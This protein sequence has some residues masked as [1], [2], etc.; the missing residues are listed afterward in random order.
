MNRL[1]TVLLS[2]MVVLIGWSCTDGNAT[3][4]TQSTGTDRG[5]GEEASLPTY[6]TL[7]ISLESK[8]QAVNVTGRTQSLESI[9]LTSEVQG[10]VLSSA[11][12]L[13]EGVSYRKGES[14]LKLDANTFSLNLKSQKSQFLATLVRLMP[15]IKLDYV[16]AHPS[17]DAYVKGFSV[18]GILPDLPEVNN[19]QLRYFLSAN[20]L[21]TSFY[22][23]KSG[24]QTLSKYTIR[25]PFTGVVTS[26]NVSRGAV[27][28]PGVPLAS[29]S[30]TDVF[31]V[32]AAISAADLS[33]IKSG[34]KISLLHTSTGKTYQGTIKRL[35]GSVDPSTQS[36]PVFIQVSGKGLKEGMFLEAS[37]GSG[38]VEQIAEIPLRAMNRTNQVHL[39]QDSIIILK[40]VKPISYTENR[41]WVSGLAE[42]D[43]V[44]IEEIL[45]P[46]VGTKAIP[47]P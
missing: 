1:T 30:R 5:L 14:M 47:Q 24:E 23:L 12:I 25:A 41:V 45:A 31:E 34:Q 32:K 18:E 16:E 8:D 42:G 28:N 26:G 21:F 13:N 36:I 33:D 35:G 15:Q 7:R 29:F 2:C 11:K 43:A 37:L 17:W 6:Q 19:D 20:N 9:Q 44:I 38:M 46:I 40:E 39:I 10:R 3:E 22:A 27:V 4:D